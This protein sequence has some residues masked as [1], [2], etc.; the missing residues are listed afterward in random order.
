[1]TYTV[2]IKQISSV[3]SEYSRYKVK[4]FDKDE[5]LVDYDYTASKWGARR[6]ARKVIR[7]HAREFEPKTVDE[8]EVEV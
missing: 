4:V 1:M 5:N 7:K 6:K 2:Q 8:Y 3:L